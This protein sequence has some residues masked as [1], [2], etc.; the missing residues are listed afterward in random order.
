MS[1]AP[2]SWRESFGR[3]AGDVA[4][5]PPSAPTI[6]SRV[7]AVGVGGA[8]NRRSAGRAAGV[9]AVDPNELR[10]AQ[11]SSV[12]IGAETTSESIVVAWFDPSFAESSSAPSVA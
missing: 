1:V 5:D 11:R 4:T 9:G 7:G 8:Q 12:E 2:E 6:A 3:T 10:S